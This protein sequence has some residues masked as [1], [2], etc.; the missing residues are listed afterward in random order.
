MRRWDEEAKLTN[1]PLPDL[2]FYKQIAEK[3][4]LHQ[5]GLN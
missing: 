1:H 5:A 4:L 2:N 3:H